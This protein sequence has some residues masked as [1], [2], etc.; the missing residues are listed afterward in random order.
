M[1]AIAE[2]RK[3]HAVGKNVEIYSSRTAFLG[4]VKMRESLQ[5]RTFDR[6]PN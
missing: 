4:F 5:T 3:H 2:Q 6:T 1:F